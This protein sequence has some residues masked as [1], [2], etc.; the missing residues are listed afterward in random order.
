MIRYNYIYNQVLQL[1]RSLDKI[2][3][4]IEPSDLITMRND[5]RVMTYSKFA[6][7]LHYG[8]CVSCIQIVNQSNGT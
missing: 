3:F 2:C 1:Y 8:V 5:C 7:A 6:E 4:P